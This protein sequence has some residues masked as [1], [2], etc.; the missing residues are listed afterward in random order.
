MRQHHLLAGTALAVLVLGSAAASAGP[1]FTPNTPIWSN[2][3]GVEQ[4]LPGNNSGFSATSGA[5]GCDATGICATGGEGNWGVGYLTHI[6]VGIK[7]IPGVEINDGGTNLFSNGQAG[8][9][10][11]TFMFY[12]VSNYPFAGGTQN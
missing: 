1:S 10:A 5:T 7:T 3:A 12:G 8:G 11:I 2:L 6:D 9:N 4:F